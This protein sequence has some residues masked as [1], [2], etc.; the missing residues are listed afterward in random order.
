MNN[1]GFRPEDVALPVGHFLAGK[2]VPGGADIAVTSPGNGRILAHLP[3]AGADLVDEAAQTAARM[4]RQSG[5]ASCAPRERAKVLR[6]WAALVEHNAMELA[7]LETVCSTRP[8]AQTVGW[9]IPFLAEGI[10][11]F[12]EYC[13][14]VG[15]DV[16]ATATNLL[17]MTVYEPT[18]LP[19]P[20]RRGTFR[21]LWQAGKWCQLL[22]RGMARC[23]SHLK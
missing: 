7:R 18:A 4:Q 19:G 3:E 15:G 5:W 1:L 6:R 8:I 2:L 11:F 13:D 14:K 22:P 10:R 21:W 9:D 20:L 17:G 12:A 16:A 23:S